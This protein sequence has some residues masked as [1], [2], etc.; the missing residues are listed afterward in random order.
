MK[1]ANRIIVI[2]GA[3]KGLGKEIAI[4]LSRQN[5][6]LILIAR[7]K[8][9]LSDVQNTIESKTGKKPFIIPCDISNENDVENMKELISKNYEKVDVLINNAGIAIEMPI[10]DMRNVEMRKQFELN[11]YGLFY[12]VKALLPLLRKSDSGYILNVGS[13]LSEL[14]FAETSV[15]SATKFA[16][17]GFSEGLGYQL[18]QYNIKVGLFL[19]G[20]MNTSFHDNK[21]IKALKI[22]SFVMLNPLK[23]ALI[24]EKMIRERKRKVYMYMWIKILMK[25]KLA[26][27]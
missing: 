1:I 21:D 7:T 26:F 23:A 16:V 17:S 11:F 24:I 12:C 2:T 14:S 20:P 6:N 25:I 8:T 4:L 15:Y 3:S 22:P 13:I 10:S 19:P 18:K 9:I 5:A 27:L